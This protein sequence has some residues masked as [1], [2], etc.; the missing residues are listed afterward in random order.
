MEEIGIDLSGHRSTDL[1][2][3]MG[4]VHFSYL[5]TV[6]AHAE[7]SCPRV[8][9]GMGRRLHWD[10]E[11]PAAFSGSE[12]EKLAKFRQVRDQVDRRIVEWLHELGKSG[13]A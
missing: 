11:D 9:P 5:I 7:E 4:K 1:V 2:E 10:L 12:E 13:A 8:F 3:Y 6:C